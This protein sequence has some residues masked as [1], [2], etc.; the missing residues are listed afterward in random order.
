MKR[1]DQVSAQVYERSFDC[2]GANVDANHDGLIR[3]SVS[4]VWAHNRCALYAL[5]AIL[6]SHHHGSVSQR[7]AA[8]GKAK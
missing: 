7:I 4:L 5:Y 1:F 3:K 2:G 6:V 8:P